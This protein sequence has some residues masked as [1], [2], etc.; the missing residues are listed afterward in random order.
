MKTLNKQQPNFER[1]RKYFFSLAEFEICQADK[2]EYLLEQWMELSFRSIWPASLKAQYFYLACDG[3]KLLCCQHYDKRH[4]HMDVPD[5]FG[6]SRFE[7]TLKRTFSNSYQHYRSTVSLEK[8]TPGCIVILRQ[9]FESLPIAR[10]WIDT[11]FEALED[12]TVAPIKGGISG[13]FH[14]SLDGKEM[15]NYAEWVSEEAHKNALKESG[16]TGIGKSPLWKKV[17][18]HPGITG[19]GSI[20]RY[21]HL[22]SI[23]L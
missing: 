5:A 18:E 8:P 1:T 13:H 16:N 11:V 9:R 21:Y 15:L 19:K 12:D 3:K 20:D 10:H 2:T 17:M 6:C 23:T 7:A 4:H 14:L 22:K